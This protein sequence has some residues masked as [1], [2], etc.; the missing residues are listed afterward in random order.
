MGKTESGAVWLSAARTSPYQFY[1]YWF[2]VDDEDAG[3]CLRM[4]TEVPRPEIEQLDASRAAAPEKRES[5]RRLAEELTRLVHGDVGPG[6]G[7]AGD[8]NLLWRRDQ[9]NSPTPSWAR[10]LPMFPAASC[11]VPGWPTAD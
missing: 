11:R 10:S 2:N 1:Q 3:K 7:P 6:G 5:Q 4:L 8:R 9:S